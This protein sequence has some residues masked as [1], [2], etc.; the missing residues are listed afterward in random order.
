[1]TSHIDD[2]RQ[3]IDNPTVANQTHMLYGPKEDVMRLG[4]TFGLIA[5]LVALT[6]ATAVQLWQAF[7]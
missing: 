2:V 3:T 6:V 7:G 4:T 5:I 1:M